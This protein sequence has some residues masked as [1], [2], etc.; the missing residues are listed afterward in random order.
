MRTLSPTF[1]FHYSDTNVFIADMSQ[2][3]SQISQHVEMACVHDFHDLRPQLS[4]AEVSVKV[5]VMEFEINQRK[6]RRETDRRLTTGTASSRLRETHVTWS[7]NSVYLSAVRRL[8]VLSRILKP[9]SH[10]TQTHTQALV[11]RY[12]NTHSRRVHTKYILKHSNLVRQHTFTTTFRDW[13]HKTER[14]QT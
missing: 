8:H 4:H 14:E 12:R 7:A 5:S 1:P 13:S 9:Y 11:T 6:T 10:H 2:T 3:L